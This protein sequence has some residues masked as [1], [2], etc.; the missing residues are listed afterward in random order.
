M[1]AKGRQLCLLSNITIQESEAQEESLSRAGPE[2][3]GHD[4]SYQK[5]PSAEGTTGLDLTVRWIT[6][7][8]LS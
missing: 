7:G 1:S 5:V 3:S 6:V 2:Y 8:R 4:G